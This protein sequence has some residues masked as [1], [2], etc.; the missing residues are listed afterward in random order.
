MLGK[1]IVP[2]KFL[3]PEAI[4]TIYLRYRICTLSAAGYRLGASIIWFDVAVYH[5]EDASKLPHCHGPSIA[6]LVSAVYLSMKIINRNH[7]EYSGQN[8]GILLK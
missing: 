3:C 2:C 1:K 7:P 5:L 4:Q 8:S 6:P